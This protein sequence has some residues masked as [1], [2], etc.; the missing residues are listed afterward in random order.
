[1]VFPWFTNQRV[2]TFFTKSS[3]SEK[4]LRLAGGQA[5]RATEATTNDFTSKDSAIFGSSH[6][7]W[8]IWWKLSWEYLYIY[9]Y[10]CV[11]IYI[12]I[13]IRTRVYVYYILCLKNTRVYLIVFSRYI[14]KFSCLHGCWLTHGPQHLLHAGTGAHRSAQERA[15]VLH[16]ALLDSNWWGWFCCM[17]LWLNQKLG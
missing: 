17:G 7:R 4:F 14:H 2:T 10:M 15:A 12:Y 6:E 9:I 1:M 11:Y 16:R 8:G 3:P 5:H 13:Y